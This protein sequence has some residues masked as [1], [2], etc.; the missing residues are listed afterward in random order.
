VEIQMANQALFQTQPGALVPPA[1]TKNAAGG[2]AYALSPEQALAQYA[3]TG[4]FGDTYYV[5]AKEQLAEVLALAQKCEPRFV[6]KCAVYARKKGHMKDMPAFLLATLAARAKG[7]DNAICVEPTAALAA[8]FPLVIDNGKMLRN[9]AQIVRSGVTG[10]KSFG[11]AVRRLIRDWFDART[12][13]QLF[14]DSVGEKPSMADVIKMVH[15]KGSTP[16]RDALY[17]YLIGSKKAKEKVLALSQLV[18]YYEIYKEHRRLGT[19]ADLVRELG[20]PDVPFQMLD[21]LGLD[22]DGWT[23]VAKRAG[24]QMLRMNLNTFARHGVLKDPEVAK[25]IADRL[26]DPGA[27][28]K[29]RVFPYQLLMAFKATEGNADIPVSIKLALQDAMEIAT[30]NVP[31]YSCSVVIAVDTSS[32]MRSPI[33]GERAAS[34]QVSCVDV[35]ALIASCVMRRNPETLVMPFDTRVHPH[36][37]NPRDSVMTNAQ[38]LARY[39]GG[40]T[41]CSLVLQAV[42]HQRLTPDLVIYVSDNESWMDRQYVS[43][44][45]GMAAE[46]AKH[47]AFNPKAKLVCI[48]LTPHANVQARTRADTL[49]VGGFSDAVFEVIATFLEE[50]DA[51]AFARTIDSVELG[52]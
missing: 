42:N 2:K 48:D 18:K 23:Q 25:F 3:V 11:T 49:N 16:E 10:R 29:A 32:S 43:T 34:S 50:K 35:A 24:W 14:R 44:G 38:K 19:E 27:I 46:W 47:K 22:T 8:A 31:A 5:G 40:G 17:A 51:D 26:R 52:G 20:V 28:A 4:T 33:T 21:S 1:D 41:D 7:P 13:D 30:A 6:A 9:F 12:G 15:P 37:L 36:D 39:G 45:T